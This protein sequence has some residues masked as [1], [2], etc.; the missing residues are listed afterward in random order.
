MAEK[1]RNL[2]FLLAGKDMDNQNHILIDLISSAGLLEKVKLLGIRQDVPAVLNALD[3]FMLASNSGE[4]FPLVIGEAMSCGIICVGTDVG[5]VRFII[6]DCGKVVQPNDPAALAQAGL[7]LLALP[8][9]ESKKLKLRSRSRVFENFTLSKM[10]EG[11]DAVY[12]ELE[13]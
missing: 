5:D 11:Y 2:T 10:A 12:R 1:N 8:D 4:A 9:D 7:D 3:L 13:S 6:A